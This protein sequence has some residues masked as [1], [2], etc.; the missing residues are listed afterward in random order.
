MTLGPSSSGAKPDCPFQRGTAS[1]TKNGAPASISVDYLIDTG[2]DITT[3]RSSTGSNFDAGASSLTASPTTGGGGIAVV[4]GII[5]H[6]TV[7][8]SSRGVHQVS[9]SRYV[10]IK[11]TNGGSDILG[12][13][14]IA[15]VDAEVRWDPVAKTGSLRIQ[16]AAGATSANM[17]DLAE[18]QQRASSPEITSPPDPEIIDHGTWTIVN[19]VRVNKP[20]PG[21]LERAGN[22][23]AL[24][25]MLD[26]W[27]GIVLGMVVRWLQAAAA[28]GQDVRVDHWLFR[29]L[30]PAVIRAP[31][32]AWTEIRGACARAIGIKPDAST[33]DLE[34]ALKLRFNAAESSLEELLF[35]LLQDEINSTETLSQFLR[36]H[37]RGGTVTFNLADAAEDR[38]LASVLY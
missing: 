31:E 33:S 28:E 13:P 35:M 2:A 6:F 1:G 4:T 36:E 27:I 7:E 21:L 5:T 23:N 9:S 16:P 20:D 18:S 26:K 22:K 8:D 29:E 32:D 12:M 19:G 37:M 15:D 34:S 11:S 17:P 14:Q 38:L 10:G 25:I 24:S 30:A 3:L